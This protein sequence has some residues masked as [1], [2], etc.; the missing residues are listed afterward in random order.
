MPAKRSLRF[1]KGVEAALRA[2]VPVYAGDVARKREIARGRTKPA[3]LKPM[4]LGAR[5]RRTAGQVY[6]G[7]AWH[8]KVV[9]PK[10]R[11]LRRQEQDA[12]LRGA[13]GYGFEKYEERERKLRKKKK[14]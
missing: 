10:R 1:T 9:G 11:G 4:S 2:A 6:Y 13:L 14:G 7:K 8:R 12:A 5:I 3:K